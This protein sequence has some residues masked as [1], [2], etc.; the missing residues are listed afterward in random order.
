MSISVGE[1]QAF[2]YKVADVDFILTAYET[3]SALLAFSA[4][5]KFSSLFTSLR[6]VAFRDSRRP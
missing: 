2:L 4:F 6:K 1:A 5:C 3:V